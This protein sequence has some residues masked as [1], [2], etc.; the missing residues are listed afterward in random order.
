MRLMIGLRWNNLSS[1]GCIVNFGSL[2]ASLVKTAFP[3]S[4]A[5]EHPTVNRTA[6]CSN[7]ARGASL[8]NIRPSTHNE[9]GHQIGGRLTF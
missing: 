1:S 6:A 8:T 2:S 3:G 7:Q 4:S 5:V 9:N